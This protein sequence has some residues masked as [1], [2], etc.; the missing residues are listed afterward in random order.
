M[1]VRRARG[2]RCTSECVLDA[3]GHRDARIDA[4][5]PREDTDRHDH[6]KATDTGVRKSSTTL[7]TSRGHPLKWMAEDA[8]WVATVAGPADP[9]LLP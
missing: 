7:V 9:R 4:V 8:A 2:E 1:T 6:V 5:C 3:S